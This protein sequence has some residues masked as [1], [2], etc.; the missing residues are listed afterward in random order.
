MAKHYPPF[1]S[2]VERTDPELYKIITGLVDYANEPG[3]IDAKT[4]VLMNLAIDAYANSHEGVKALSNAA[5]NLGATEGEIAETLR[6]AY[7]V[8][9]MKTLATTRNAYNK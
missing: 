3:E 7:A 1:V 4:K 8:A 5:R 2:D 9:G 6:L